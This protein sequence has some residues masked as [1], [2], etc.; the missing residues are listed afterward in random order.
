MKQK[1]EMLLPVIAINLK[2]SAKNGKTPGQVFTEKHAALLAESKIWMKSTSD[3]CMLIATIILTVVYAAA[4]TVPGGTSEVTGLPLLVKGAWL[5][6]FFIFEA[7]A[8]FGATMC[9]ITFWSITTSGFEEY[10]FLHILPYQLKLGF[11]SLFVS[12]IGAISAFMSAYHLM[13]V[14]PRDWLVKSVLL[15]VYGILMLAIIGRFSELWFQMNLPEGLPRVLST[16]KIGQPN[17]S[18][19][20]KVEPEPEPELEPEPEPEPGG[21]RWRRRVIVEK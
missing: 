8:L 21:D 2:D 19:D 15:L 13:L 7:V 10:Q 20:G 5:T 9:I 17:P 11:T 6:L 16:A 4:F 12:L 18:G 3:S 1:V 14:E